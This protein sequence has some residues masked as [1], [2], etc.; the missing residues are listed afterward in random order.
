MLI[1]WIVP[2]TVTNNELAKQYQR[3]IVLPR[4][5]RKHELSVQ[6]GFKLILAHFTVI[7]LLVPDTTPTQYKTQSGRRT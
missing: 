6:K 2:N 1:D 5:P 4:R 7:R 3:H